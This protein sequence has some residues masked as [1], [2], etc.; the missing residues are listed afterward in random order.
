[1]SAMPTYGQT[2]IISLVCTGIFFIISEIARL[3]YRGK[4]E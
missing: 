2:V 1:M 3:K 4:E